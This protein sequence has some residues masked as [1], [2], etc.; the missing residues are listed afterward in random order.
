MQTEKKTVIE[1]NN[2]QTQCQMAS[3]IGV[4]SSYLI[5]KVTLEIC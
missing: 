2:P 5:Q 3:L 1:N 4:K